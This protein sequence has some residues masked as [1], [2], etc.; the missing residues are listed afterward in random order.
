MLEWLCAKVR[1]PTWLRNSR[2]VSSILELFKGFV[3]CIDEVD[4]LRKVGIICAKVKWFG[5]NARMCIYL[6][7]FF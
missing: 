7:S 3:S 5:E 4:A 1:I 6:L 2:M